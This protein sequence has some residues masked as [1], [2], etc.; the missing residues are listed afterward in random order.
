[1]SSVI[2]VKVGGCVAIEVHTA[3]LLLPMCLVVDKSLLSCGSIAVVLIGIL[4]S[5]HALYLLCLA[6]V[7]SKQK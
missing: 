6:D 7:V 4:V 3:Q 1:M 2:T 5:C